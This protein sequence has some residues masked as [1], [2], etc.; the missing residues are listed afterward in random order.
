ME[1]NTIVSKAKDLKKEGNF[2][3]IVTLL[4]DYVNEN[5]NDTD[6]LALYCT[7][8]AAKF[9]LDNGVNTTQLFGSTPRR[10]AAKR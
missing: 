1:A 2:R 7:S 4:Q 8:L 5:S 9:Y 3:E 10:F 6:A